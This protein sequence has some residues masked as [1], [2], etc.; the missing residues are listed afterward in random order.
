[1]ENFNHDSFW[2]VIYSSFAKIGYDILYKV[3][4]MYYCFIDPNTPFWVKLLIVPA[5]VYLISPI[6]AIPDFLP[7]GFI[8]DASVITA[9][10]ISIEIHITE[11]HRRKARE[12]LQGLFG[13]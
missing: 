9:A 7:A 6:D 5:I 4:C 12:V 10:F 11:E 3:L 13:Y 2:S 1:M 8:D